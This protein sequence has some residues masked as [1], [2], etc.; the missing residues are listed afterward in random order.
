MLR[1]GVS[2][3]LF[4]LGTK[5]ETNMSQNEEKVY[6]QLCQFVRETALLA[7]TESALGW[8]ERTMLPVQ[9]AEF[10]ADQMTLL[11]GLIHQRRTGPP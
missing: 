8:D 3:W 2:R 10:R 1:F 9:A 7:A 5:Y 6:G 4:E 11:A